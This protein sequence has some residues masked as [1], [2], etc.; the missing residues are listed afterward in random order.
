MILDESSK[1]TNETTDQLSGYENFYLRANPPTKANYEKK[2]RGYEKRFGPIISETIGQSCLVMGCA[3]GML[4]YYLREKKG[5]QVVG[6]DTNAKLLEI[7]RE[8]THAE[9]V[10]GD[11]TEY[12]ATCER[13]FDIVFLIN[14]LEHIPRVKVIPLLR[15]LREILT[16]TGCIVI[17]TP[18]LN[19]LLGAAHFCND[20]THRNPLNEA[21]L[22]QVAREA[23][24]T[25]VE[26]CNQFRMQSFSGKLRA[27]LNWLI[28]R[29]LFRLRGGRMPKVFYRN[30]YARLFK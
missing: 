20:F 22:V 27:C 8:N 1:L 5:C 28:H 12:A 2:S 15:D 13:R 14:L 26:F 4:C 11:A 6:I 16:D 29:L 25:R 7:A 23:G 21:S 18:N 9:F 19:N 10:L 24:L 3:T 30:L 17:R